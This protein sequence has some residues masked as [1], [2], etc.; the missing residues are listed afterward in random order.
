MQEKEKEA[1]Y[2]LSIIRKCSPLPKFSNIISKRNKNFDELPIGMA[3]TKG[4]R[5]H[6]FK[7][8]SISL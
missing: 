7:N 6:R 8:T 2:I 1:S 3:H 4:F 5:H